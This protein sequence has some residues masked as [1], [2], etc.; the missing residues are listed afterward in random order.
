MNIRNIRYWVGAADW[1]GPFEA[2][3]KHRLDEIGCWVIRDK[4]A[5]LAEDAFSC[6]FP[7]E[8]DGCI[9]YL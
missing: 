5:W 1:A 2:A 4:K 3:K 9:R 6:Q 8:S 7:K